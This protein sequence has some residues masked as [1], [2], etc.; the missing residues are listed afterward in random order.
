MT[1]I[2]I[3]AS[4][5]SSSATLYA[6]TNSTS[7]GA[8]LLAMV[9]DSGLPVNEIT[10]ALPTNDS[11]IRLTSIGRYSDGVGSLWRMRNG[12]SNNLDAELRSY[13][14]NFSESYSLESGYDTYTISP[15]G[16]SGPLTHILTT[17]QKK[18]TKAASN[19]DAALASPEITEIDNYEI[20]GSNFKDL[21][22]GGDGDDTL[23]GGDEDDDLIGGDGDDI[24]TG[25]DGDDS[26]TGG[27]GNDSLNGDIG[28]DKFIY[29]PSNITD[30]N[31]AT[32]TITNFETGADKI[33]LSGGLDLVSNGGTV[34]VFNI[35][36]S[37]LIYDTSLSTTFAFVDSVL[38]SSDFVIV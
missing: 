13:G 21:I 34:D 25:G 16:G 19:A 38:T 7:V 26:L 8:Q 23:I 31:T 37:S 20:I 33:Q 10:M 4:N 11:K 12:S 18:I 14:G 36:G 6:P 35:G 5:A 17:T 30:A 28:N 32:D 29:S 3:N 27:L 2:K 22:T 1:T 24:L 15:V 9:T